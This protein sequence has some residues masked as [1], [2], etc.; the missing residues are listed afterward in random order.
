MLKL[1]DAIGD[2]PQSKFS[3]SATFRITKACTNKKDLI[4][5]FVDAV[6]TKGK[7]EAQW[8]AFVVGKKAEEL[9]RLSQSA[10]AADRLFTQCVE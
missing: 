8:Q 1:L 6:S 3:A 7:V 9:E 5:Q 10:S 4:V 2:L